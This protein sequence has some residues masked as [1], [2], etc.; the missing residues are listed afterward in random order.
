MKRLPPLLALVTALLAP[1][2]LCAQA[3]GPEAE[4]IREFGQEIL[5]RRERQQL[6]VEQE[7]VMDEATRALRL[8]ELDAW[9]RRLPGRYRIKGQVILAPDAPLPQTGSVEGIADCSGIGDGPGVNC[10]INAKWPFLTTNNNP[11]NVRPS[12]TEYLNTMR[13]S[14]LVFG[15]SLDPPRVIS[16]MVMGDSV[17]LD[18]SG[19]LDEDTLIQTADYRCTNRC[20]GAFDVTAATG[21]ELVIFEMLMFNPDRLEGLVGLDDLDSLDGTITFRM[22]RD[23][24][25]RAEKPLKALKSR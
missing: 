18:W 16:K 4:A 2:D 14:V 13:P 7:A 23:P 15:L 22:E 6:E 10:I 17:V 3:R 25:A 11:M 19:K 24:D 5:S 12:P 8:E 1:A 21:S 20:I 9:L